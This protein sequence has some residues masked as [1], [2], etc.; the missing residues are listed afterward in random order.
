MRNLSLPLPSL[1]GSDLPTGPARW[2]FQTQIAVGGTWS[3]R[4]PDVWNADLRLT[5][6]SYSP[7]Q[8]SGAPVPGANSQTLM[9][10]MMMWTFLP[11]QRTYLLPCP[12]S[13]KFGLH[14]MMVLEELGTTG[15]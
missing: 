9:T 4:G 13:P 14:Q 6:F 2:G 8:T 1:G 7:L 12:P 5:L 15:N 3:S 10:T 11:L